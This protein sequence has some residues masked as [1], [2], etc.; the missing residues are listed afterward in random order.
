MGGLYNMLF[1]VD[2]AAF[3]IAPLIVNGHPQEKIAR[4]R[5]CFLQEEKVIIFTRLGGGNREYYQKEIEQL[6]NNPYYITDYDDDFDCTYAYFEFVIP[7]KW[8]EDIEKIRNKD[9]KNT[10]DEYKKF[11][12]S[13]FPKI[14]DKLKKIFYD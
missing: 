11:I 1:G 6:R 12:I 14:E 10:S 13:T 3:F 5:D 4:F 9:F 7:D 8:R 2:L